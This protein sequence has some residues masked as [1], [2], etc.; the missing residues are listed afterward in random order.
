MAVDACEEG[1]EVGTGELPLERRSNLLVVFLEPKESVFE[2]RQRGEV[3]RGEHLALDDG[4]IDF[5]LVEPAGMNGTVNGNDVAVGSLQTT[6]AGATAMG[7]AVVHDPED[8]ASGFVGWLAH[9][10]GHQFLEGDDA[11][12]RFAAA[13][14]LHAVNVHRGQVR[15]GP[16]ALILV[17]D[18]RGPMRTGRPGG[19]HAAARLNAGLLVRGD[20]EIVAPQRLALPAAGVEVKN[21]PRLHTEVRVARKD[22]AP[23][24]PGADGILTEPAPHRLVADGGDQPA[25][26]DLAGDVGA[27]QARQWQTARG[28]QFAGDRLNQHDD[29]WGEMLGAVPSAGVPPDPVNGARRNAAATDSPHRGPHPVVRQ[30]HRCRVPRQQGES[31]WLAPR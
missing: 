5:D 21:A 29:L 30:S 9:H 20:H 31:S 3:V 11:G 19:M 7:R 22:P 10:V 12:G 14:E 24:L 23:M 16:A 25:A 1:N 27:T 8:P 2:L 18:A 17:L 6:H 4:E 15:P 28:G 26:F 13:E